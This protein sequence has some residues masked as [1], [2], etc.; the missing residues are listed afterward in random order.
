MSKKFTLIVFYEE[1][2]DRLQFQ[3][4]TWGEVLYYLRILANGD[5]IEGDIV[6]VHISRRLEGDFYE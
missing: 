3:C 6:D 4:D 1:P 2:E 5:S